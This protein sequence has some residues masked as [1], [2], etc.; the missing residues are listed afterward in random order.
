MSEVISFI[1]HQKKKHEMV[2]DDFMI[3]LAN[4]D[5]EYNCHECQNNTFIIQTN[6]KTFCSYCESE[7]ILLTV[8]GDSEEQ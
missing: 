4:G 6:G 5:Y 3:S 1:E 2:V 8:G 7:L